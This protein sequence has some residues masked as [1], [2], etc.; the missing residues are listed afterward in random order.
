VSVTLV[1]FGFKYGRP[2]TNFTVD[3]SF[4]RNPAREERW[5]LFSDVDDEMREFVL[6]QPA[7]EEFVARLASLLHLVA[8]CDDDVRV[9]VGCSAGRHR[10]RV[11][12]EELRRR[13]DASGVDVR[14]VHR[15]EVAA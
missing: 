6:A 1:T 13:L 8:S 15:E 2:N 3:V 4:L 10:S 14:V 11:I 12:A 7:A 9:G 5:T